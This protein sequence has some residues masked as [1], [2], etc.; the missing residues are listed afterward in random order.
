MKKNL[1]INTGNSWCYED[2]QDSCA[3]YGR[4]YDWETAKVACPKGW[5][6]PSAQEWDT[7]SRAVGG[8]RTKDALDHYNWEGAGKKLKA[9]SGWEEYCGYYGDG[10]CISGTDDYGFSAI[11]APIRN[12]GNF[13]KIFRP[14]HSAW[15][16]A[17]LDGSYGKVRAMWSVHDNVSEGTSDRNRGLPIRCVK[18]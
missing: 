11:A 1:N 6:L 4:V 17:T 12:D 5:H 2:S 18:D 3:K 15:W 9:T 16:T 13:N 14:S 7:L 8:V 10:E